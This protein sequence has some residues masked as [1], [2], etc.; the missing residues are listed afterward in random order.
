MQTFSIWSIL[1]AK[2]CATYCVHESVFLYSGKKF[3]TKLK[4]E[5][6]DAMWLSR[7]YHIS[8]DKIYI[9]KGQ[10]DESSVIL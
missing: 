1:I 10:N 6:E 3:F 5:I 9:F 2:N 4:F 7:Y 8:S